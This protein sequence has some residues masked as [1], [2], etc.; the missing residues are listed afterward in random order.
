M[1][2]SLSFWKGEVSPCA[3]RDAWLL[4]GEVPGQSKALIRLMA[5]LQVASGDV[6]VVAMGLS[7]SKIMMMCA[8]SS[9]HNACSD[10]SGHDHRSC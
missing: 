7:C 2:G 6:V 10:D 1:W 5:S 4:R 8:L 3:R 9:H